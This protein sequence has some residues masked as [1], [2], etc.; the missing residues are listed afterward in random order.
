MPLGVDPNMGPSKTR[1]L[2]QLDYRLVALR[3]S[4]PTALAR[5]LRQEDRQSPGMLMMVVTRSAWMTLGRL[6][7]FCGL[8]AEH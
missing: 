3:E 5:S 8:F 1:Q 6:T 4:G 2:T 7:I